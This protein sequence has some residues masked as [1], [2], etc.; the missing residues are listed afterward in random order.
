MK[1]WTS[2]K[3]TVLELQRRNDQF[4]NRQ[5]TSRIGFLSHIDSVYF[6]YVWARDEEFQIKMPCR[7][8]EDDTPHQLLGVE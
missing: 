5:T 6:P 4:L 8:S 1:V 7:V 3:P 2:S